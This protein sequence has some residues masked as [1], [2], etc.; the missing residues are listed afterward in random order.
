MK[1]WIIV[2]I[3]LAGMFGAYNWLSG[4]ETQPERVEAVKP[5]ASPPKKK[6]TMTPGRVVELH[7][8][9][10]EIDFVLFEKDCPI[11]TKRVADLVAAGGYN[12]IKFERVEPHILIQTGAVKTNKPLSTIGREFADG[13]TNTKGTVGMARTNDPNSATSVFYI[14]IEPLPQLNY[15]YTSFGRLIRGMEVVT[16]IKKNDKIL[17]ATLRPFN[18]EDKKALGKVLQTESERRVN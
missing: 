9:H 6:A 14:L 13:L 16:S 8:K 12:G 5:P 4:T 3:L 1:R 7:T 10:G 15:E 11:T 18:A 17:S 2:A